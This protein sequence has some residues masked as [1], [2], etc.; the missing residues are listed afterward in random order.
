MQRSLLLT[1]AL[2]AAGAAALP[3]QQIANDANPL[4]HPLSIRMSTISVPPIPGVPFFA[5]ALI[6]NKQTMPDGSVAATRNVNLIGRDSRGRT[7]GEMRNRVPVSFEGMPPLLEVH[8]Y[9]PQTRVQTVYEPATR[10]ARRSLRP[11]PRQPM[12]PSNQSDASNPLVK[13]EDL[14]SDTIQ[15]IDVKGTRRTV[16]IPAQANASGVELTI[17]DEYW[18]SEDLHVNLLLRHND[19]RTGDQTVTL[20]QLKREEPVQEFFEVPQDCKIVDMT[21]PPGAPA[22]RP[23]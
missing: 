13:V 20:S 9:D 15:N 1:A 3:A 5:V 23:R 10:I 14:G 6:E 12:N 2:L 11:E 16:T 4:F 22:A 18:Y 21:P 17:V 19:P 8:L 7:H